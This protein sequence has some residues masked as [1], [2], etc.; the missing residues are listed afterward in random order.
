MT[1]VLDVSSEV[2]R[3]ADV[4]TT[5][6]PWT[7]PDGSVNAVSMAQTAYNPRW[8]LLEGNE[9]IIEGRG[10]RATM[11]I[12]LLD[13]FRAGGWGRKL[14]ERFVESVRAAAAAGGGGAGRGIAIGIASDNGQVVQFY[15]KVGFKL[16]PTAGDGGIRMARDL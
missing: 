7:R 12:D 8:L 14:I 5:R 16:L 9:D 3:P 6:E 4:T 10:Y 1:G 13:G 11:H 15:E 2:D